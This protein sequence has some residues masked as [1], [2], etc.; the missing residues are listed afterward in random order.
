V[1]TLLIEHESRPSMG[2]FAPLGLYR[3]NDVGLR[4]PGS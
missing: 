3:R 4:Y 2:G 1:T